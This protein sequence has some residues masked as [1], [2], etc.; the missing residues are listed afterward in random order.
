MVAIAAQPHE[1]QIYLGPGLPGRKI[2]W[3]NP[4][5]PTRR[6]VWSKRATN[7]KRVTGSFRTIC[8]LNRLNNLA[9]DKYGVGIEVIQPPYNTG[10]RASAGT[11][12]YDATYDVYI[13]GVSWWEQQR[14]FRANG[15]GGWYRHPP[16]FGNHCHMFTLPYREG[17]S[18]SDDWMVFGFKVGK[19]MDGGWSLYRRSVAS[20]QI[21]DYYAHAFGLSGAHT[22]GSDRSWFPANIEATI[23]DLGA[24]VAKRAASPKARRRTR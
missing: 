20:S 21:A 19:Y 15:C 4:P 22:P 9:I 12:D 10:V 11:H 5:K 24:Y 14:F 8:H 3:A 23:F 7:G 16:L 17:K 1:A 2:D 6:C 18:I 13:P